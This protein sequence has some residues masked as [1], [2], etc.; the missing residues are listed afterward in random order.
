MVQL[1]AVWFSELVFPGRCA[2]SDAELFKGNIPDQSGGPSLAE[3]EAFLVDEAQLLDE[4]KFED[5]LALFTDDA[6][7]WVPSEPNRKV[8]SPQCR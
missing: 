5:W 6:W 2:V 7:Y 1:H 8:R 3:C 4:G